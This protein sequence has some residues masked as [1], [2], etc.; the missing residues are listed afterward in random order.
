MRALIPALFANALVTFAD[1]AER[2]LSTRL[3]VPSIG[4]WNN[5]GVETPLGTMIGTDSEPRFGDGVEAFL[6]IQFA[7]VPDRFAKSM[8]LGKDDYGQLIDATD[9]GPFCWQAIQGI[10]YYEDQE[11]AEECLFLNIWRPSGTTPNSKLTIMVWIHGGGW[12]LGG[13]P[14]PPAWGHKLARDQHVMVISINY[15]LGIF[16]FLATDEEG[17]NGM[18]AF[19]DQVNALEWIHRYAKYFGGNDK[20]VTIF[21]QDAGSGS[22]CYLS[23]NPLAQGLFHRGIMQ[24]GECVV[25][26]DRPDAIGL[27]PGEEGYDIT[28]DILDS[29]GAESIEDLA[30]RDLFP[31]LEIATARQMVDPILD[32]SILP[33]FPS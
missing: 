6:G 22:V 9:F 23:V 25:G 4:E 5:V 12:G 2:D 19:D 24:S 26:D 33:D 27:L 14:E 1:G 21:G 29:L 32:K 31:A 15:R 8:L 10:P 16:G 11:Q 7:A 13:A 18:N 3:K 17:S 28:L 30:D 20:D